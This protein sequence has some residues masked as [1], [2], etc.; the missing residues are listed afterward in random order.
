MQTASLAPARAMGQAPKSKTLQ[1]L[2]AGGDG[3][4]AGSGRLAAKRLRGED[5][6]WGK[7][8][9]T[10]EKAAQ[11]CISAPPHAKKTL[12]VSVNGV[13]AERWCLSQ[14]NHP[15]PFSCDDN[16]MVS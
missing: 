5:E 9:P 16:Y 11:L 4:G 8:L 14:I 2:G 7:K 6:H 12:G 15:L 10:E 13:I 3:P 1:S